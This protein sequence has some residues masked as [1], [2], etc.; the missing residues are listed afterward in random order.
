MAYDIPTIGLDD[1]DAEV[2][3]L[4]PDDEHEPEAAALGPRWWKNLARGGRSSLTR[5]A[6]GTSARP[7]ASGLA[8]K[9]IAPPTMGCGCPG[10]PS[11]RAGSPWCSALWACAPACLRM[12]T[13]RTAS[14]RGVRCGG[15]RR[16]GWPPAR[17]ASPY[18]RS[19]NPGQRWTV[20]AL[21]AAAVGVGVLALLAYAP[22]W[23]WPPL[24]LG[25]VLILAQ[26]GKPQGKGIIQQAVVPARYEAP[27]M[28]VIT[29]ALGS[30]G[31]PLL[32]RA[33]ADNVQMVLSPGVHRDGPG[34][35]AQIGVPEGVAAVDVIGKRE[36]LASALRGRVCGHLAC[37]APPRAPGDA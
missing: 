11:K 28:K 27:T 24:G 5:C 8:C 35:C 12:S 19:R 31:I 6:G 14:C 32:A 20:A 21:I 4:R 25:A 29:R 37:A 13:E 1:E 18:P 22:W 15:G 2:I 16:P 7:S 10:M 30:L 17:P 33:V 36:A 26:F 3:P 9:H 23:V 34:W